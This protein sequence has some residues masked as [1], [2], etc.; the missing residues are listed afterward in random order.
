M[1]KSL[2]IPNNPNSLN[3]PSNISVTNNLNVPPPNVQNSQSSPCHHALSYP[4]HHQQN[5]HSHSSG[6]SLSPLQN[7][8]NSPLLQQP[9]YSPIHTQQT[10]Q[11]QTSRF[12]FPFLGITSYRRF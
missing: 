3:I 6:Q 7:Q 2:T 11:P 12:P 9:S 5:L 1:P 4:H 8:Q 10:P